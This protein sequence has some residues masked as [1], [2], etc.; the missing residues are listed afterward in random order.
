M[1]V[2]NFSNSLH[3]HSSRLHPEKPFFVTKFV[4]HDMLREFYYSWCI[5]REN[6]LWRMIFGDLKDV[7]RNS[8]PANDKPLYSWQQ[9][10]QWNSYIYLW[11]YFCWHIWLFFLFHLEPSGFWMIISY[12]HN[13]LIMQTIFENGL[14]WFY[15]HYKCQK[16]HPLLRIYK[17]PTQK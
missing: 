14:P 17:V 11:W 13:F 4:Y 16:D 6:L 7:M 10:V 1:L 5:F 9:Y 15:H 8:N 2:A 3:D 12:H